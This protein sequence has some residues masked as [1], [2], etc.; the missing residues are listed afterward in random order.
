[1]SFPA[2]PPP[3]LNSPT[4]ADLAALSA[5]VGEK[6]AL[7]DGRDQAAYL[8]ELRGHRSGRSRLVLRPGNSDEVSAILRYA[9]QHRLG[10]VPQGGN[11]GLVYGQVPDSGGDNIVL[12]LG[13]LNRIRDIDTQGNTLTLEAGVILANLQQVAREH[14]RFF[15]LSLGAEGSCQVGGN[16][17]TNA[18]GTAV[19]AYG[20]MRELVLGL[21]VVLAS[22]EIWNGLKTLRKDNTGYDMKQLF[23][24]SEGTLGV[25][26]AAVVKLFPQPRSL[27]TALIAL[28]SPAAALAVMN[29]LND[30][31]SGK[32]T[33]F[34]LIP[35]IG[36][37]FVLR[38]SAAA[39]DPFEQPYPWYALLEVSA[40]TDATR[41]ATELTDSLSSAFEQDLLLDAA[42]A[43]SIAQAQS[44]WHLRHAIVECQRAEGSY[45][46]FDLSVPLHH[47]PGFLQASAAQVTACA[48]G[49]RPLLFGHL[50]DGNIHYHISQPEGGDGDAFLAHAA[51]I[52]RIIEDS[53]AAL[54][55]SMSAEHGIGAMKVDRLPQWKTPVELEMMRAVKS[56][57]DPNWIL[58]P[59]KLLRR[60]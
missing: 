31:I 32:L 17:A 2:A 23:I 48:P 11:S 3:A 1:M 7:G 51:G 47:I 44:F 33:A 8:T 54:G 16:I 55:G 43:A 10:I 22:G 26:T 21:E 42:I 35:R 5:I 34:E 13:R 4:Q 15:P 49:C 27:N 30:S 12:N 29:T 52:E 39:R 14:G 56:T 57:L 6:H 25:V 40:A 20:N 9:N 18:G 36:I 38:H 53:V 46:K 45:M 58:N 59:G 41:G 28:E 37:E 50:G 19:L 60:E 24:G